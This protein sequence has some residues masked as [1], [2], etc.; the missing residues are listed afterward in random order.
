LP[1]RGKLSRK[2]KVKHGVAD[3]QYKRTLL[4]KIV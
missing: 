3:E 2:K 4:F 1:A